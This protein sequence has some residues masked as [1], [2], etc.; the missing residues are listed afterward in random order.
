MVKAQNNKLQ[1]AYI[2]RYTLT[3]GKENGLKVIELDNGRLRVL[4]NES[5]GLDIMQLFHN[6][7]NISFVSRNGFALRET[8][9]LTRFE[10][11][12]LYTC[13]LD[14]IG[15]RNGFEP[16][17][18]F[19]CNPAKIISLIEDETSLQVVSEVEVTSL[20]G[21][22]LLFRRKI[23][24]PT[25]EEK[26]LIEDNLINRGTKKENYCLLYHVNLG[27]PMLDEGVKILSDI[28]SIVPRT[29]YA[30]EKLALRDVF[31]APIDN[32]EETCYFLKTKTDTISVVNQKIN[33]R[34]TLKYSKDTLPCVVQWNSPASQDYALGIEPATCFLDDRFEYKTIDVNQSISFK[35]EFTLE[36]IE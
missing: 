16:H 4:L 23:T 19:H 22:N 10:G 17:G 24:L 31:E 36:N 9:F 6:G 33:K 8:P 35:L 18:T 27:Y 11:G 29:P 25:A 14:S 28:E 7:T 20:F 21:E 5:K 3:D 30:K 1:K 34:F 13:G 2:R 32:E 26:L 15:D 12:M